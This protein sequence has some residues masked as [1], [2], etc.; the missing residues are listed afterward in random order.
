MTLPDGSNDEQ[1]EWRVFCAI[2][3]PETIRVRL[4]QH[5][6]RVREAASESKASWS[7]PENTHLTLRFF[8]NLRRD[9]VGNISDATSRVAKRFSRF[10][11][12]VSETGVFPSHDPPKVLWVGIQDDSGKLAELHQ[13]LEL[14]YESDGFLREHRPFR[15]HLTV[16]R[17]RN[18][19]GSRA[20]AE[21]H[22]LTTFEPSVLDV[23]ELVVFRSELNRQGS[24]YSVISRHRLS[25]H[26]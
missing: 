25:R 2:E 3:I 6:S 1:A 14:E 15:P 18:S 7:R 21:I 20:L 26:R 17:V 10:L 24:K 12:R 11:V 9:L 5:I 8:G 16:A 22:R 4:Q 19:R 23:E 13:S